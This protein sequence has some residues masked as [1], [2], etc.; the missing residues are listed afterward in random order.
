MSA[1]TGNNVKDTYQGLLKL[2]NSYTGVTGTLQY[3]Q[4][5]LGNNIPMLVS[6]SSVV[7]TGSFR[8]DGSGLTG[9]TIDTGSLVTTSSFNAY[10]QSA[11]SGVSASIGALSSSVA[12]TDLA[13]SSSIAALQVFSSSLDATFATDAQLSASAS[14]LQN[15]INLKVNTSQ[16]SSMTVLSSSYAITASF[17]TNV[18]IT[19]SYAISASQAETA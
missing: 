18:P 11:A 2:A 6:T 12:V 3:V 14:T 15:E 13:Q 4:D 7:I 10:T 5:G 16:T 17:A 9:L 8:G 19:A 1:L